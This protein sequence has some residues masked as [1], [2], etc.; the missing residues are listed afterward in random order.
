MGRGRGTQGTPFGRGLKG[1]KGGSSE[2][3]RAEGE[4]S[5]RWRIEHRP[6]GGRRLGGRLCG[7]GARVG[8]GSKIPSLPSLPSPR[9]VFGMF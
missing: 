2:G 1:I 3:M 7:S 5:E 8:A 4:G 6:S 9:A